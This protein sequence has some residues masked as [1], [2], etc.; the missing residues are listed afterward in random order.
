MNQCFILILLLRLKWLSQSKLG[1]YVR[2]IVER[3]SDYFQTIPEGKHSCVEGVA[4]RA[5]KEAI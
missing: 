5:V 3:I 4:T 2:S 1:F